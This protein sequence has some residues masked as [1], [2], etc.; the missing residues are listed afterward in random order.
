M[1][2]S[3]RRALEFLKIARD[4]FHFSNAFFPED[5]KSSLLFLSWT[6]SS[7]KWNLISSSQ[8]NLSIALAYEEIRWFLYSP[9]TSER[10]SCNRSLSVQL[11]RKREGF[12]Q[13]QGNHELRSSCQATSRVIDRR[14]TNSIMMSLM[15]W[16][17]RK[18][19]VTE[20]VTTRLLKNKEETYGLCVIERWSW[21]HRWTCR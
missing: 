6:V 2:E 19:E 7:A 16:V 20:G 12:G 15:S 14:L 21:D 13:K 5:L 4:L 17:E 3:R 1:R 18:S 11:S 8:K 9:E 10:V